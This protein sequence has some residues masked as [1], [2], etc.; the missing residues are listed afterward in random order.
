MVG[1][2]YKYHMALAGAKLYWDLSY[3]IGFDGGFPHRY[4]YDL[5]RVSTKEHVSNFNNRDFPVPVNLDEYKDI[6]A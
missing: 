1:E 3:V 4:S 6:S 2:Y 5:L